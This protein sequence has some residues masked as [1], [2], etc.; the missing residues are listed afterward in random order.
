M[1]TLFN[2]NA[3]LFSYVLVSIAWAMIG[4]AMLRTHAFPR[5]CAYAGLLAGS[6]GVTAVILEH[7]APDA[8][9]AVPFYFAAIV[10]LL[11]WTALASRT[12]LRLADPT[13][14]K[15]LFTPHRG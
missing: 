6:A 1:F 4:A 15:R 2:E 8:R 13:A 7:V 5:A 12:L 9:V 14:P 3:F 11:L 10:L